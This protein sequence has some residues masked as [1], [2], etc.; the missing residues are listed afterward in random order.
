ARPGP[1]TRPAAALLPQ[2]R[3]GPPST[4]AGLRQ[5][6]QPG[7]RPG[8]ARRLRGGPPRLPPRRR[9]LARRRA[10][11]TGPGSG[12]GT[13]A[14]R[15]RPVAGPVAGLSLSRPGTAGPRRRGRGPGAVAGPGGYV[16]V[17]ARLRVL[18][19]SKRPVGH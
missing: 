3:L 7:D 15:R 18:V 14:T 11:G 1:G 4:V 17:G 13:N 6:A 8:D 10:A 2:R 19:A 9:C 16:R 12:G 5:V